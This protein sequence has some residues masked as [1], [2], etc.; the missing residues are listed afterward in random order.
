MD[1]SLNYSPTLNFLG[2][3]IWSFSQVRP[4]SGWYPLIFFSRGAAPLLLAFINSSS[5][6]VSQKAKAYRFYSLPPDHTNIK[7]FVECG[8]SH[9]DIFHAI[10]WRYYTF[11]STNG[12]SDDVL[13][14]ISMD[15]FVHLIC[16]FTLQA[17]HSGLFVLP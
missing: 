8:F 1:H 14:L 6:Q 5:F 12:W 7:H 13:F 3:K 10:Y 2:P 9:S 15:T 16:L 17:S 11:Q 4:T